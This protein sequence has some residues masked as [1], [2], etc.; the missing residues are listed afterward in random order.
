[1]PNPRSS[2]RSASDSASTAYFVAPVHAHAG[3]CHPANHGADVDD[4]A[5]PVEWCKPIPTDQAA[6]LAARIPEL[7][8]RTE[9]AHQEAFVHLGRGPVTAP[10][11]QL[12]A[13]SLHDWFTAWQRQPSRPGTRV[14]FLAS[15]PVTADT[16]P[17]CDFAVPLL[18]D[19]EAEDGAARR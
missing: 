18:D 10:Q 2:S 12:A 7:N 17:D 4:P 15:R 5:R 19:Y 6:E 1:M 3:E 14:T 9:L 16:A 8:L 11:W 13:Q